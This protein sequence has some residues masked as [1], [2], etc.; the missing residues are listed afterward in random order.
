MI[1]NFFTH[2][3]IW[4]SFISVHRNRG[5]IFKPKELDF[6]LK[7]EAASSSETSVSYRSTTR[8]HSPED[9]DLNLYSREHLKSRYNL[10]YSLE[11]CGYSS[12]F[13]KAR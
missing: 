1:F 7:M 3:H 2:V 9:P 11:E 13:L 5:D 10:T 6:T 8:H 4:S 12:A